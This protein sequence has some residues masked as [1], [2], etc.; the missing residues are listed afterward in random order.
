MIYFFQPDEEFRFV[1]ERFVDTEI[2]VLFSELDVEITRG[3]ILK[4]I[5]QLKNVKNRRARSV[6]K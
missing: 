4:S 1:Q 6:T 3:K 2:Q 5:K